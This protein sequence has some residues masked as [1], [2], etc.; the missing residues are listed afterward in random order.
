MA[1]VITYTQGDE[2]AQLLDTLGARLEANSQLVNACI[3]YI[4]SS[5]LDALVQ[6]WSQVVAS[7][8]KEDSASLQ[9]LIE[10]AMILRAQLKS[11][12]QRAV[13]MS[14]LNAR[15][16]QYARLLADQGCFLNAYVYLQDS[17][18]PSLLLIKDRVFHGL[19][20]SLV[21]QYRLAKPESP[22]AA[23]LHAKSNIQHQFAATHQNQQ[24]KKIG[25]FS[26]SI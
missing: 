9:D 22:F 25:D 10:K 12:Q 15:L 26:F 3:C 14:K 5:N 18:D 8:G 19:D 21:Q 7:S 24:T 4:C 16:I 20:P 23:S 1:S 13:S 6:C 2:Q 11:Q 17:N